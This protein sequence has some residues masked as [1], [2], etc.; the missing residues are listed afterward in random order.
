MDY[1]YFFVC[2]IRI[3]ESGV[4]ILPLNSI[5]LPRGSIVDGN[6]YGNQNFMQGPPRPMPPPVMKPNDLPKMNTIQVYI[7]MVKQNV[8]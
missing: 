5:G 3:S 6:K 4:G 8:T 7:M 2:R 1:N